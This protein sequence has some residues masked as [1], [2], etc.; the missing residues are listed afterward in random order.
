MFKAKNINHKALTFSSLLLSAM[1]GYSQPTL[2]LE[3]C[4]ALTREN[5]PLLAQI[6]ILEQTTQLS[7][8]KTATGFLPQFTLGGQA[9]YQSDVTA[10]PI[11]M[12]GLQ[13]P[14]MDKDQYKIY[15]EIVQP[16]TDLITVKR[17]QVFIKA[18]AEADLQKTEVELYK[19]KE[20]VNQL[21]FSILLTD[22]QTKQIEVLTKDIDAGIEK[23]R[24]AIAN[25][26]ALNSNLDLL[27]AEKLKIGQ[28]RT[29]LQST[30][31]GL[32]KMLGV[33]FH[34]VVGCKV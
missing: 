26:V 14:T 32:L 34:H 9:T 5:Y 3:G 25:G 21:Y 11:S 4:H 29:E 18:A 22:A 2:T 6:K 30:R 16:I 13:I 17:N 20:R 8:E 7:L 15:G 33:K 23:T 31:S 19:L 24:A 28:R 1:V 12:P 27:M 10:I